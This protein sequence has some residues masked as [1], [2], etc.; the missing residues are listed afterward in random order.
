[1][2]TSLFRI[3]LAAGLTSILGYAFKAY[4]DHQIKLAR[5]SDRAAE[6]D[7]ETDGG[8]NLHKVNPPV[9]L[10]PGITRATG[11]MYQPR[12]G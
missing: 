10:N 9:S 12:G 4:R 1:M 3:A 7:W 8:N 2:G 5:K 11:E 6:Q